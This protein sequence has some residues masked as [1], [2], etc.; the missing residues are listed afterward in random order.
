MSGCFRPPRLPPAVTMT[1]AMTDTSVGAGTR[2]I[3]RAAISGPS[4]YIN[5]TTAVPTAASTGGRPTMAGTP[6]A[7]HSTTCIPAHTIMRQTMATSAT[8][9]STF[10]GMRIKIMTDAFGSGRTA[11]YDPRAHRQCRFW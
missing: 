1:T 8:V 10:A 7:P 4:A 5:S 3:R 11:A 9:T 2:R 6:G